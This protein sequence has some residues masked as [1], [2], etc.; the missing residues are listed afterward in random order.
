MASVTF[1]GPDLQTAFI[2]SLKG[3]RI[4]LLPCP[5]AWLADGSLERYRAPM[6]PKMSQ[7]T[8]DCY[9]AGVPSGSARKLRD[10]SAHDVGYNSFPS[11]DR[12]GAV[13]CSQGPSYR[14]VIAERYC[15]GTPCHSLESPILARIKKERGG[16]LADDMVSPGATV[17][18]SHIHPI[19]EPKP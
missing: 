17:T 7:P 12:K 11:R 19:G 1:G 3:S 16:S 8:P 4:P 14:G 13:L 6:M 9:R 10:D 5:R 18:Y 2:G 15:V